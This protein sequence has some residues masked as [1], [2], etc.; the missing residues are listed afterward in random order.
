VPSFESIATAFLVGWLKRDAD[1]RVEQDAVGPRVPTPISD[2]LIV[3]V[4]NIDTGLLL[5]KHR[6]W[7]RPDAAA[8]GVGISLTGSSVSRLKMMRPAPPASWR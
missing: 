6:T 3:P 1:R 2:H 5:E 4:S 8:A 7:D